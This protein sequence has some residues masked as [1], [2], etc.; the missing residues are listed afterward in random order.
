[1]KTYKKILLST[2]SL[3]L[4]AC[5][6]NN[7][8]KTKPI[9]ESATFLINASANAEKRLHFPIP[10]DS[11]GYAYLEC[12]EGK[13]SKEINCPKLFEAM[14][15]FAKENHFRAYKNLSLSELTD[16]ATFDRIAETYAENAATTWPT[17]YKEQNHG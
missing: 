16:K 9:E 15:N 3:L 10:E 1:V 12:M 4:A 17:F 5:F 13:K 2:T 6:H 7:P 14:I 8:L 11:L